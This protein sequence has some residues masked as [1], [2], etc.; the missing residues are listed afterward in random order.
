LERGGY[1]RTSGNGVVTG[2][3]EGKLRLAIVRP[4]ERIATTDWRPRDL[5]AP[6]AYAD[7]L[8]SWIRNLYR[9]ARS[10]SR[11][12]TTDDD[13]LLEHMTLRRNTRGKA[14]LVMVE[15]RWRLPRTLGEPLPL[16]VDAEMEGDAGVGHCR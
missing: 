4:C 13:R 12:S 14:G 8:D 11:S 5:R 2:L 15:R 9:D 16:V 10:S 7:D 3:E 1:T 6:S